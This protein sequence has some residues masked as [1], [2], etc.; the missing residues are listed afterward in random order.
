M[1]ESDRTAYIFLP[2]GLGTLDEFFV[3]GAALVTWCQLASRLASCPY[4]MLHFTQLLRQKCVLSAA[5]PA[6]WPCRFILPPSSTSQEI[7]TLVQLRKLGTKFPVPII[8]VR[9]QAALDT[10]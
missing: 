5:H 3:S 1:K 2:G 7:L 10:C 9:R 4:G 6:S 8:L